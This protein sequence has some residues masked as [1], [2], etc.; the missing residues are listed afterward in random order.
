MFATSGG[1]FGSTRRSAG[2]PASGAA[3]EPLGATSDTTSKTT[4]RGH[5]ERDTTRTSTWHVSALPVPSEGAAA[6]VVMNF[7][8]NQLDRVEAAHNQA[9]SA[10]EILDGLKFT[11]SGPQ[12]RLQGGML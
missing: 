5:S 4:S 11:G 10:A 7:V 1:I 8:H 6:D 12:D 9:G 3:P 2:V